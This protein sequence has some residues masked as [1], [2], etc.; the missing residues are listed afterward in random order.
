MDDELVV[1][2]N[3]MPAAERV[4]HYG[5]LV[6]SRLLWLGVALVVVVIIYLTQRSELDATATVLL[7]VL[8]L[9]FTTVWLVIALILWLLAKNR[10]QKVNQVQGIALR[11]SRTGIEI[12]G[13]TVPWPQVGRIG[14]TR[15]P[16]GTGP[17]LAVTDAAGQTTTVPF[18]YL[19]TLPGSLDSALR[20]YSGG[21]RWLDTSGLDN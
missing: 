17:L 20:A 3:P 11:V 15:G 4:A 12:A 9:G 6:R 7:F 10:L 18:S 16:L 5:R 8:G 1:G 21:R 2:Y 19:D 13:T 14:T